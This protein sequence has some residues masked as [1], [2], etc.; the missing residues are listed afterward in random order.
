MSEGIKI[1]DIHILEGGQYASREDVLV[2][3]TEVLVHKMDIDMAQRV[4]DSMWSREESMPTYLENG[5]AVPHARVSGLTEL[6]LIAAWIPGG[7]P[8][9][10]EDKKAE[11]V[12]FLYLPESFVTEYLK[13]MRKLMLWLQGITEEEKRGRWSDSAY[14]KSELIKALS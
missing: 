6:S 5:L 14:L 3:M 1:G 13:V 4:A 12:I 7:V 8:W 2:T 10:T 9:P 11:L